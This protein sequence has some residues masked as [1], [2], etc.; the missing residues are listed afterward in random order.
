MFFQ[1]L[2]HMSTADTRPRMPWE[3]L[4]SLNVLARPQTNLALS[5][6]VTVLFNRAFRGGW[7]SDFKL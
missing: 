1:T 2:I 3:P 6:S 7:A 4:T 5:A